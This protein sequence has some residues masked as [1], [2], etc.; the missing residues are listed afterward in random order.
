MKHRFNQSSIMRA[1]LVALA[2]LP[3]VLGLV[4]KTVL[5]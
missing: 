4:F 1:L 3:S 2:T 5:L